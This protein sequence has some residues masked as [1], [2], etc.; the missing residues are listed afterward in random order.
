MKKTDLHECLESSSPE[1]VLKET[2][3]SFDGVIVRDPRDSDFIRLY[4]NPHQGGYYFRIPAAA[5]TE[6]FEWE[7]EEMVRAGI[8]GQVIHRLVVSGDAKIQKVSTEMSEARS[9]ASASC[10]GEA[11]RKNLSCSEA[12]GVF[13]SCDTALEGTPSSPHCKN[14]EF[15]WYHKCRPQL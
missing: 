12:C 1:T 8:F 6:T 5:I 2:D 15:P 14:P 10:S 9:F 13:C 3:V 4:T 7:R 11:C